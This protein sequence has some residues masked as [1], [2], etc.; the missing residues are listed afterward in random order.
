MTTNS[1]PD[2]ERRVQGRTISRRRTLRNLGIAGVGGM[3][4]LAGCTGGGGDGGSS[5]DGGGDGG[6][7]SSG[8]GG[9]G[10][11]DGGGEGSGGSD[12]D[13]GSMSEPITI[14]LQ[15]DLTGV[16][17]S[18]GFW[19]QR[20][21]EGYVEELNSNGGIAGRD[22]ELVVEDTETDS[23][24]GVQ[25]M[26]K[27]V[28]SEGADFVIGSQSSGVSIATNPL[29]KQLKVPYFP[30][31]E[32]PSIT[33]ADSNRW[34][35][36]N[37]HSTGHAAI[38]AVQYGLENL[39]SKWTIMYQDYAFGQ[40][41]RDW[42]K[43]ELEES[44]GEVLAEIAVPVGTSDL[45]SYLNKVPDDTEVLFNALVGPSALNFLKQS[46]D[47]G[48]PGSRLGPIASVE[49]VD[50]SGLDEGAEGASYVTML[51]REQ[52]EFD[53]EHNR[54]LRQIARVDSS[55]EILNGGHYFVSYE[56]LSWIRDAVEATGWESADGNQA[57]IEWFEQGPSVEQSAAY[58]QG[59]KFFR[60]ED[61]QAFM[62]MFIEEISD[63]SL[64]VV[65]KVEVDSPTFDVQANLSSQSF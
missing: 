37:N 4:G 29:A 5:G 14:G 39:G 57:F 36:R 8:D 43:Q 2:D 64:S 65:Q 32:A 17:A 45:N 33:G 63:G 49:G 61:H 42:V 47:L 24:Q 40:Q 20:V 30:I 26:R 59:P 6:G 11:E 27:L 25:A 13:G 22:V 58:P 54:T 52:S 46:A 18:Y 51:P 34:V 10:G 19:H 62:D 3:A 44:D 23:K 48:T 35:V 15:A 50:V 53:N 55:D 12:G 21:L 28:Q 7:G 16:L 38:I 1:N 41:Y 60:G 31:G 9:D 56:A